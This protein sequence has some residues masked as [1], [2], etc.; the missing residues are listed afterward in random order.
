[1][2]NEKNRTIIQNLVNL[3]EVWHEEIPL[4]LG[5]WESFE[6]GENNISFIGNHNLQILKDSLETL[7]NSNSEIAN[8]ISIKYFKNELIS[9]I[10]NIKKIGEQCSSDDVEFFFNKLLSIKLK[11]Y[12]VF[13]ILK[14]TKTS[15]E[16]E[17]INFGL[18]NVYNNGF[19]NIY[20][21]KNYSEI[22]NRKDLLNKNKNHILG[23]KVYAR[24][25]TKT[26]EIA[27]KLCNTFENVINYMISDLHHLRSIGVF[28]YK[29]TI[30][31]ETVVCSKESIN[32]SSSSEISYPVNIED[33][34]FN[35]SELGNDR[36]WNILN[37]LKK[38]EIEERLINSI[39]WFGKAV[40]ERDKT[41][42]LIQ[43]IFGI[44]SML[45]Y[46][47]KVF[48]SPSIVSQLS[49]SLAFIIKTN[50][51][52]RKQIVKLFKELYKKRSA[53]SH[54]SSQ[55]ILLSDLEIILDVSQELIKTLLTVEPYSKMK[56]MKELNDYI[57]ELKYK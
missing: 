28:N 46:N 36:I 17:I 47:E 54:G 5:S 30:H 11:E 42:S 29:G 44:E 33:E 19:S 21:N 13:Y 4:S 43:F 20:L 10:R 35:S 50:H 55:K 9:T 6:V 3:S 31:S 34:F 18:F 23:I 27:D 7:Y 51:H 26:I 2:K 39:E 48:I 41:K 56:T 14:G 49:D 52:E 8:T 57:N 1:M 15:T 53:I 25:K 38:T 37:N 45:Q 24:E 40:L 12:E 22:G 16:K 32:I